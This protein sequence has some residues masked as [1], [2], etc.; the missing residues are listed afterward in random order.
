MT[1][2]H[3]ARERRH[4]AS[5]I[6][7]SSKGVNVSTITVQ[8]GN[9]DDKLTQLEWHNFVKE[10][11]AAIEKHGGEMHFFGSAPNWYPW[12]N[13]AFVFVTDHVNA[14]KEELMEL[15]EKYSQESIA[16]TKGETEFV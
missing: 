14:L 1:P 12:Q 13:A 4:N 2:P 6:M 3:T 16:W 8:I 10:T 9:S 5:V 7:L 11:Q 15:R